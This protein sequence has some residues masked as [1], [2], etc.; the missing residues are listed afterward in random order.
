M[1]IA[2]HGFLG[3]PRDWLALEPLLGPR[4]EPPKTQLKTQLT[5]RDLWRDARDELSLEAWSEKFISTLPA[6]GEKPL[7]IGY[8]MGGRLAMHAALLAPE[9]FRGAVFVSANPGLSDEAERRRR[10]ETDSLWARRFL[11]DEWSKI[12]ADW[13]SQPVLKPAGPETSEISPRLDADF[14]R[15]ALANA[16]NLW[17]LGRQRD[18]RRELAQLSI[19]H[20]YVT[21]QEDAKFTELVTA[22]EKSPAARTEIIAGA[23]HRVP[24]EKPADFTR[25]VRS[26][27]QE[28]ASAISGLTPRHLSA[29]RLQAPFRSE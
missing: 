18:L 5:A 8:S 2:L 22:M 25:I 4:T 19:P 24:W 28:S 27:L 21:G 3:L 12:L 14:D 17:S 16:M 20:C 9:R 11:S 7:L 23:G 26:M 15:R 10:I 1:I 13:N 6:G 29:R